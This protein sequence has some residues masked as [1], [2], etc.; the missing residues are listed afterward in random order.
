MCDI[1]D[2]LV[3]AWLGMLGLMETR[4]MRLA[5]PDS[6]DETEK[7]RA[8]KEGGGL[9]WIDASKAPKVKAKRAPGV[10]GAYFNPFASLRIDGKKLV[11]FSG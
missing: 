8:K 2:I 1:S 11:K 3:P 6:Q 7:E 10:S 9:V 4:N 5:R